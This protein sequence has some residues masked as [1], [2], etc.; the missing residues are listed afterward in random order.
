MTPSEA[1][2]ILR[3]PRTASSQEIKSAYRERA[4]KTH[5]DKGGRAKEF[6]LV[7]AAYEVL[8]R[9]KGERPDASDIPIPRTL[10]A[11][12]DR[13]VEDFQRQI[14]S[15]RIAVHGY[16]S[17]FYDSTA[18]FIMQA[19]RSDLAG[20]NET[21]R[22]NWNTILRQLLAETN[23]RVARIGARYEHWFSDTLERNFLSL[24]EE[25]ESRR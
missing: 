7:R 1:C 22:A 10:Q 13:I 4:L 9:L 12:I 11:V 17:D 5:P 23:E 2:R 20:F 24:Q 14:E 15:S 3:V 16:M 25:S 21:F 6:I 19:R 8:C 18:S